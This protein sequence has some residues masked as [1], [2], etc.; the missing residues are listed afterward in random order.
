MSDTN[1]S[2][3]GESLDGDRPK[4]SG[5]QNASGDTFVGSTSDSNCF[6]SE[7]NTQTFLNTV[8]I[9]RKSDHSD[10][11]SGNS[12]E[13]GGVVVNHCEQQVGL[14]KPHCEHSD[15]TSLENC[16]IFI[17]NLGK[18]VEAATELDSKN[19][20][21]YQQLLI[22]GKMLNSPP[23][24]A[25]NSIFKYF[26][27]RC[28]NFLGELTFTDSKKKVKIFVEAAKS[29]QDK[30]KP[31]MKDVRVAHRKY[32]REC[33]KQSGQQ[34]YH[35]CFK[36]N[37]APFKKLNLLICKFEYICNEEVVQCPNENNEEVVHCPNE[38]VD[39]I[40]IDK[41]T[42]DVIELEEEL[43]IWDP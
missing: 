30:K 15:L 21:E 27:D 23:Y 22:Y 11:G 28:C 3:E 1:G 7:D 42:D 9:G 24:Y 26:L 38:V 41:K 35:Q 31:F 14:Q 10:S 4:G 32:V 8:N 18:F 40:F 12:T 29:F 20:S 43:F 25:Y 17:D 13:D 36:N 6:S 16:R 34:T 37:S 19:T 39:N 5:K 33:Q 2:G